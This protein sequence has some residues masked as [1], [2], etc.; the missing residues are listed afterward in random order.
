MPG[1]AATSEMVANPPVI[2]SDLTGMRKPGGCTQCR[3][4]ALPADRARR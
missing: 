2:S 4:Q 3:R 1:A